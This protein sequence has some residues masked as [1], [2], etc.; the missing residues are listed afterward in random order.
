MTEKKHKQKQEAF[1]FINYFLSTLLVYLFTLNNLNRHFSTF[2]ELRLKVDTFLCWEC[3]IPSFDVVRHGVLPITQIDRQAR[4]ERADEMPTMTLTVTLRERWAAKM[5]RSHSRHIVTLANSQQQQRRFLPY[6]ARTRNK[7][8]HKLCCGGGAAAGNHPRV[9]LKSCSTLWCRG[10]HRGRNLLNNARYAHN[11]GG[12]SI[13]LVICETRRLIP[14][15]AVLCV[16]G[17]SPLTSGA[18]WI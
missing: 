2:Y 1:C 4:R 11:S 16:C 7:I 6:Y 5:R 14:A 3:G 15:A 9:C 8:L 10:W 13:K 17:V 12:G 18:P